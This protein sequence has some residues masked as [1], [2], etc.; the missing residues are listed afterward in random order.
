[1]TLLVLLQEVVQAVV[2]L[3]PLAQLGAALAASDAG[4]I[5][6]QAL[7]YSQATGVPLKKAVDTLSGKQS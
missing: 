1:M 4:D 3:A 5:M 7:R 6:E 2:D